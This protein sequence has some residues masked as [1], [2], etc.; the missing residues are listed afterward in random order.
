MLN[1]FSLIIKYSLLSNY[2][3]KSTADLL[4]QV[5]ELYNIIQKISKSNVSSENLFDIA[6][7]YF[8]LGRWQDAFEIFQNLLRNNSDIAS[9]YYGMALCLLMLNENELAIKYL[10]YSF[11][12]NPGNEISF[13]EDFPFLEST[14]LYIKLTAS[15]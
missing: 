8:E 13:L 11:E 1:N 2:E 9:S 6:D 15:I 10:N 14:S 7:T 4:N 3:E 12:L 5:N